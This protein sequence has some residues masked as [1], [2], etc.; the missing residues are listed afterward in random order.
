MLPMPSE[1]PSPPGSRRCTP[2]SALGAAMS[3]IGNL[4]SPMEKSTEVAPAGTKTRLRPA[5]WA[6]EQPMIDLGGEIGT[7][8]SC[9]LDS[10]SGMVLDCPSTPRSVPRAPWPPLPLKSSSVAAYGSL[11]PQCRSRDCSRLAGRSSAHTVD[12]ISSGERIR[13]YI[14]SSST[15]KSSNKRAHI[16]E[17]LQPVASRPMKSRPSG[18]AGGTSRGRN[19]DIEA[20]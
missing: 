11:N 5:P 6:S 20:Q 14:R 1:L 8:T 13:S 15:L 17:L 19:E 10:I 3:V 18:P 4:R 7:T 12:W 16:S 2:A 9:R